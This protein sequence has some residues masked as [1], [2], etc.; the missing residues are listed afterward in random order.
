MIHN[1]KIITERN[2]AKKCRYLVK[3]SS[4]WNLED[5]FYD[6]LMTPSLF[7]QVSNLKLKTTGK[8]FV[9]FMES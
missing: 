1:L 5:K 2:I 4:H 7:I 8:H 6:I 9:D 3:Q